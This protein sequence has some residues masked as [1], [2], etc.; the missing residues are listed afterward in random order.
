MRAGAGS[1]RVAASLFLGLLLASLRAA[2]AAQGLSI[3]VDGNA[4]VPGGAVLVTVDAPADATSVTVSAF[5]ARWPAYR[6][7]DT[8]WRALVGIDLDRR[9]G[10]YTITVTSSGPHP[11][12]VRQE[13]TVGVK[14]F[15][16]RVLTVSPDFVNPT[17]EQQARI[18]RD[19][20]FMRSVYEHSVRD[21]AWSTG[22]LRPVAQPANSSFGTR[23]VFNGQARSPHAGTDFLSPAGTPVRAPAGG[24]VS[25]ARD[26]YFTGNTVV[27]DH[28]LGVFSML[29]H[30]SRIDVREGQTI[31]AGDVLGLV[32]A[33]GRVTGPHLHWALRIGRARVDP[34]STLALLGTGR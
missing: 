20:E 34:L 30:L 14:R 29:A 19:A 16:R 13:L 17:P 12:T 25:A 23:S 15:R 9:P 24:H 27:I 22:M 33:T 7:N 6:V 8:S 11:S 26:L 2:R 32:G 18:A 28:G 10:T 5:D 1:R 21:A 4:T 3:E 31:A